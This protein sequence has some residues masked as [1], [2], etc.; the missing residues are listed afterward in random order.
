[1]GKES[2]SEQRKVRQSKFF[3]RW[4]AHGNFGHVGCYGHTLKNVCSS[5]ISGRA[6]HL[7]I[8]STYTGIACWERLLFPPFLVTEVGG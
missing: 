5:L 1:M 8:F 7:R 3:T 4:S 2:V 6:D